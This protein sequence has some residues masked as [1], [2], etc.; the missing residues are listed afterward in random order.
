MTKIHMRKPYNRTKSVLLSPFI[1]R[2]KSKAKIAQLPLSLQL[3][4][5]HIVLT[6][7]TKLLFVQNSKAGC[8]T[9][10]HV[11]YE[12]SRGSKYSGNIHEQGAKLK[13]GLSHVDEVLDALHSKDTVRFTIVRDPMTRA[14]SCFKNFFVDKTNER[15]AKY[16]RAIRSFGYSE[17]ASMEENFSAYLNLVEA[18][19]R[20]SASFTDPHFRTQVKNVSFGDINYDS[21]CKLE[22]Y[23]SDLEAVFAK[24][25]ID[26]KGTLFDKKHNATKTSKFS[27]TEEMKDRVFK[28][29]SEDYEAFGYQP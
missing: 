16:I 13:R 22:N 9:V 15:S 8:T 10:S 28:I 11:M 27:P 20:K 2:H 24:A 23:A 26:L 18:S 12:Y 19:M 29:Y 6:D 7:D 14:L 3:V 5:P 4:F 21:I 17:Q 1:S 25:Q